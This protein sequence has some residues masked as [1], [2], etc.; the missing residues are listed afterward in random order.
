M[1]RGQLSEG[2]GPCARMSAG[3]TGPC[4]AK[5]HIPVSEQSPCGGAPVAPAP[6]PSTSRWSRTGSPESSVTLAQC[7][8]SDGRIPVGGRRQV[9]LRARALARKRG[10][11]SARSPARPGFQGCIASDAHI[12]MRYDSQAPNPVA[13]R[14]MRAGSW[15]ATAHV[16]VRSDT[17]HVGAWAKRVFAFGPLA[18]KILELG[19]AVYR[20]KFKKKR[21]R[22]STGTQKQTSF[23]RLGSFW[24]LRLRSLTP[25]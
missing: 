13:E 19:R 6:W 12:R 22:R 7:C 15:D 4:Y 11:R 16:T 5:R 21:Y 1:R 8:Y 23:S 24:F 14:A 17:A 20:A 3:L 9:A 2:H 25:F 10:F 18:L